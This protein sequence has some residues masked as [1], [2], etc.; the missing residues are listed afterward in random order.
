MAVG[1]RKIGHGDGVAPRNMQ[2][3]IVVVL[4]FPTS[5]SEHDAIWIATC[6]TDRDASLLVEHQRARQAVTAIGQQDR[7]TVRHAVNRSQQLVD[8][9]NF[10]HRRSRWWQWLNRC[11]PV[12]RP[13]HISVLPQP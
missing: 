1:K 6:T 3:V 8:G 13:C 5:A 7:A 2:Y 12:R 9:S 11:D 4:T 10:D